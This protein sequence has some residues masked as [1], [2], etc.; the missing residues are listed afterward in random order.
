[1]LIKKWKRHEQA[2]ARERADAHG[3][4]RARNWTRWGILQRSRER[5]LPIDE[6]WARCGKLRALWEGQS[7][8]SVA[9]GAGARNQ[10]V[11]NALARVLAHRAA[12]GLAFWFLRQSTEDLLDLSTLPRKASRVAEESGATRRCDWW[13]ALAGE[14]ASPSRDTVLLAWYGLWA[15]WLPQFADVAKLLAQHPTDGDPVRIAI[16][17]LLGPWRRI[18]KCAADLT[19]LTAYGAELDLLGEWEGLHERLDP[20][21]AGLA[22]DATVLQKLKAIENAAFNVKSLQVEVANAPPEATA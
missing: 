8:L 9:Y 12:R 11:L 15:R 18:S 21:E 17:N 4:K 16:R 22:E 13:N 1:L 5:K 7:P 3:R 20:P 10:E 6:V 14:G 2:I 19:R